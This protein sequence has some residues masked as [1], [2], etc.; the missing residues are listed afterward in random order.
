[1]IHRTI[2]LFVV[3]LCGAAAGAQGQDVSEQERGNSA[4]PLENPLEYIMQLEPEA[5]EQPEGKQ[6]GFR[7]EEVERILPESIIVKHRRRPAGKNNY[8]TAAVKEV[9]LERLVPLLVAAIKEQQAEIEL[10]K[11]Q[12]AEGAGKETCGSCGESCS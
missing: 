11:K 10:L 7:V 4:V 6:H 2:F 3:L 9:D 1:M 12:M 5:Y 8:R